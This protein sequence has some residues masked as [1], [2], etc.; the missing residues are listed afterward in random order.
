MYLLNIIFSLKFIKT[1][2]KIFKNVWSRIFITRQ[3]MSSNRN[4]PT[5]GDQKSA[6]NYNF[7]GQK[8]LIVNILS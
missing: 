1:T 4:E 5:P 2:N 7:L 6:V 3:F 8:S